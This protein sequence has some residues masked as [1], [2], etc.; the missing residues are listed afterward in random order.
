MAEPGRDLPSGI[1]APNSCVKE[2]NDV[3]HGA[4]LTPTEMLQ[5]IPSTL[6]SLGHTATAIPLLI[7]L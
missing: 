2:G 6:L 5:Q 1:H 3:S 4:L 7:L